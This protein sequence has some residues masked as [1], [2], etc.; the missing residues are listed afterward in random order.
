V[1]S[2]SVSRMTIT[3]EEFINARLDEEQAASET[4]VFPR[5]SV[6]GSA[7]Y[8]ANND[9]GGSGRGHA[10]VLAAKHWDNHPDYGRIDWSRY[11]ESL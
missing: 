3:P 9:E 5:D 10:L 1:T 11:S 4:E 2:N 8:I 7:R 6:F